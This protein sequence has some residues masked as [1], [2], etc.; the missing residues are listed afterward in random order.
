MIGPR[1]RSGICSGSLE[2]KVSRSVIAKNIRQSS[3]GIC[4][5][6]IHAWF[7]VLWTNVETRSRDESGCARTS[8]ARNVGK[9][10]KNNGGSSLETSL[11][12]GMLIILST[13]SPRRAGNSQLTRSRTRALTYWGTLVFLSFCKEITYKETF[14]TREQGNYHFIS[15][16][17][18]LFQNS[19]YFVVSKLL[20]I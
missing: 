20:Y 1:S 16:D 11:C 14:C 19:S 2:G 18:V 4:F 8:Y 10:N 17:E 9:R 6:P 12:L 7:L 3:R 5:P 15:R 13:S